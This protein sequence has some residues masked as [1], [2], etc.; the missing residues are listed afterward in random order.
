MRPYFA[1]SALQMHDKTPVLLKALYGTRALRSIRK[2]SLL[3]AL[4]DVC[5]G[6]EVVSDMS[7]LQP[8]AAR[9]AAKKERNVSEQLLH[10]PDSKCTLVGI[11]GCEPR[12]RSTGSRY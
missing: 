7:G 5:E 9:Y 3:Q 8:R 10:V 4:T 1:P 12:R 11:V 6:T 2:I